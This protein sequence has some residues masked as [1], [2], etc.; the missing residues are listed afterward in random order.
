MDCK[1]CPDRPF[2]LTRP[3]DWNLPRRESA[4]VLLRILRC[5]AARQR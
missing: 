3:V 1:K 2:C 5:K 4:L